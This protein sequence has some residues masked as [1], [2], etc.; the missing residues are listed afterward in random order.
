VD[1]AVIERYALIRARLSQLG[2]PKGDFD[3]LIAATSIENAAVLV[4]NDAGLKDGSIE[5]L[6]VE[7]WLA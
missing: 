2:R 5:G 6:T 7:D 3:L 4:T 1:A